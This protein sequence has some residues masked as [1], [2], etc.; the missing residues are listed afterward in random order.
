MKRAPRNPETEIPLPGLEGFHEDF[1]KSRKEELIGLKAAVN[2]QQF[3]Q[4]MRI[5]HAW[6]GFCAPYGFGELGHLS[7]ELSD[8]AEQEKAE[9]CQ[10]IIIEIEDYLQT[11]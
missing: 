6:K 5:A 10:A 7:S 11:K 1:L 8:F 9:E 2:E 3:P 4:I